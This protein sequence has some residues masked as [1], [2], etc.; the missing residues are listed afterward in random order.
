LTRCD[1]G[2]MRCFDGT[3]GVSGT[4][5]PVVKMPAHAMLETVFTPD[6]KEEAGVTLFSNDRDEKQPVGFHFVNV[7]GDVYQLA[8]GVG[9]K[10][11]LSKGLVIPQKMPAT[12]SIEFNGTTVGIS[13]NG[14]KREE[15]HLPAPLVD[16]D[17]PITVGTYMGFR[18]FV[19]KIRVFQIRDLGH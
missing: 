13:L 18:P 9:D 8:L 12:L 19:G 7:G 11:I 3:P 14:V 10:R 5:L 2:A 6:G 16:T 4:N 1:P 15:M 17:A